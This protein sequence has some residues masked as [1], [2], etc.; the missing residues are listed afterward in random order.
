MVRNNS[1]FRFVRRYAAMKEAGKVRFKTYKLRIL[2][3]RDVFDEDGESREDSIRVSRPLL[4]KFLERAERERARMSQIVRDA[5]DILTDFDAA[6][7][8]AKASYADQIRRGIR[9]PE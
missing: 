1:L 9:S 6:A 5:Q 2:M 7:E 8:E 3:V 4:E